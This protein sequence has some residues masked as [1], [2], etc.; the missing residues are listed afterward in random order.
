MAAGGAPASSLLCPV[1]P[2]AAA[3]VR[4][5]IRRNRPMLTDVQKQKL[6]HLF[7]V[8]DS[9][10]SGYVTWADYERIA[11]NIAATRSHAPGSPEY[12]GLMGQYRFGWEQAAPFT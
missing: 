2:C 1:P 7:G 12:E 11:K 5:A 10:D 3:R 8:M 9:D 6:T 4:T